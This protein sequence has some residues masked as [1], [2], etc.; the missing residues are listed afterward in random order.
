MGQFLILLSDFFL[1][2]KALSKDLWLNQAVL[3]GKAG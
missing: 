2:A 1:Q 3:N